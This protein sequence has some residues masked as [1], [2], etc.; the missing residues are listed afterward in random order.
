MKNRILLFALLLMLVNYGAGAQ[1]TTF[2]FTGGLQTYTVPPGVTNVAI[3]IKGASG[4]SSSGYSPGGCGGQVQCT[5][6]VTPGQVLNVYVGGRGN[7]GSYFGAGT[8]GTTGAFASGGTGGASFFYTG[9]GG[10]GG[11]TDIRTGGTGLA[12]RVVAAGGGGGGGDGYC[13]IENG[14]DGGGP[15]SAAGGWDCGAYSAITCGD[16][17]SM[18]AGGA[19]SFGGG[20]AGGSLV[21]GDGSGY[22]FTDGGGGG[23]GYFG[24]GGGDAGGGGGG[25]NYAGTGTSA[26]THTQGANC[27]GDGSATI[28]VLC[29]PPTGGAVV[30]PTNLCELASGTYTNP[31]GSTGGVWSTS[32]P[33]VATIVAGTGAATGVAPG[34]V[35]FTYTVTRTCGTAT[36]SLTVTVDPAPAPI[37]GPTTICNNPTLSVTLACTTPGGT[38]SSSSTAVATI[39]SASGTITPASAGTTT[40]SYTALGCAAIMPFTVN[41][42]PGAI[43]GPAQICHGLT[44]TVTATPA[45]GT[46]SSNV[47]SQITVD[48]TT[49]VCTGVGFSGA[50]NIIYTLPTG[51]SSLTFMVVTTPPQPITGPTQVCVNNAII[52]NEIVGGGSWSSSSTA[53]ATV[54]TTVVPTSEVVTGV[55]PG[56]VTI[57]YA[58]PAC[59]PVTHTITVN[60]I[61]GIITGS[62]AVCSGFPTTL[63]STTSGGSWSSGNPSIFVTPTGVVTSSTIGITGTIYY[64]LPTGCFVSAVVNVSRGPDTIS[65]INNVCQGATTTLSITDTTGVWS[66]TN[67]A[68]AT[69]IYNTGL[70]TGVSAGP[71]VISYTLPNGCYATLPFTVKPLLPGGVSIIDSPSGIICEGTRAAFYATT[72]NGGNPTFVW[73]K[74]SRVLPGETSDTLRYVPIHGDVIECF[75]YPH[76]ICSLHDS[77][78]DSFFL[79]VYPIDKSP[80][81]TISTAGPTAIPYIGQIVTFFANVT[82]G[83]TNPTYQWIVDGSPVPGATNSSFAAPFYTTSTVSCTVIGNPPCL[84]TASPTANSNTIVIFNLLDVK[85]LSTGNNSL[86]LFPN[87]NTGDFTLS[88]QLANNSNS[89]VSMEVSNM[90]GQIVYKGKTTPVNGAIKAQIVLEGVS[91]GTYLLRVNTETGSET[92]HFV[93]GK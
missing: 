7:D 72:V 39:G 15:G 42:L 24:G 59:P 73:K 90:L 54:G 41:P 87:P 10:G 66:S 88:G 26:V 86:S 51:C 74:F 36:A 55:G 18:A 49:G 12:N 31:T 91:S 33:S 48:P 6:A 68:I 19:G 13:S 2:G 79:D 44:A 60:P 22:F 65:G 84:I 85:P 28:T 64:T 58:T 47:P 43:S 52:L 92:F 82:W 63:S 30:G 80:I 32:D 46:W 53:I 4:G 40:I 45:G 61:P 27:L 25:S 70:V 56:V 9:G 14:G 35:T 62:T 29:T 23:G 75:M 93:I 16:G 17:A 71:A 50:A 89:E 37:T 77:V 3:D 57:S 20:L 34:V 76:N 11:A 69:V 5:L 67:L 1:T 38:W 21:G 78:A 83:G 81:V 8:G